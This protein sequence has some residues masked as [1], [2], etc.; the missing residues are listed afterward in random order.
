MIKWSLHEQ[1]PSFKHF[2]VMDR[3]YEILYEVP[4]AHILGSRIV[5]IRRAVVTALHGLMP[6]TTVTFE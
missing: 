6:G 1:A 2:V 4:S 3:A 5:H